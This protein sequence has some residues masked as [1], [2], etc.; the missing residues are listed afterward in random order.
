VQLSRARSAR[1]PPLSQESLAFAA[2]L[3]RNA[4][5]KIEQGAVEPRLSTVLALA[6]GLG[7]PPNELLDGLGE[8]LKRPTTSP[9]DVGRPKGV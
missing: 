2:G 4:I 8:P 6:S 7:V 3:H 9:S 5:Y 1:V